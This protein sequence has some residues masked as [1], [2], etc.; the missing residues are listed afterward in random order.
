M[1]LTGS[2]AADTVSSRSWRDR[3]QSLQRRAS[4]TKLNFC[5]LHLAA[6]EERQASGSNGSLAARH[7]SPLKV[8]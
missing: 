2:N 7:L 6:I 5:F 1:S 3:Q 8:S 4:P